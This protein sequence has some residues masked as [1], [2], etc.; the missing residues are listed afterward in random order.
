MQEIE[1]ASPASQGNV[2]PPQLVQAPSDTVV[3]GKTDTAA[4]VLVFM[5]AQAQ[6]RKSTE[7]V[8]ATTGSAATADGQHHRQQSVPLEEQQQRLPIQTAAAAAAAL[9]LMLNSCQLHHELLLTPDGKVVP[10][11]MGGDVLQAAAMRGQK[12]APAIA[13]WLQDGRLHLLPILTH[14]RPHW[15]GEL[16]KLTACDDQ[17]Q[18]LIWSMPFM[19]IVAAGI[20]A[21][22]QARPA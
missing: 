12:L 15:V 7:N 8:I 14:I 9:L 3:D 18:L 2:G 22:L 5:A 11:S 13:H 6:L 20:M 21:R 17:G 16:S 10:V 19:L 4:R 1:A